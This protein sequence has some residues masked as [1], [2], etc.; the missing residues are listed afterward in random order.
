MPLIVAGPLALAAR[1]LTGRAVNLSRCPRNLR[2]TS[3]A[4][5]FD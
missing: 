2:G 1:M 4:N 5:A 3:F